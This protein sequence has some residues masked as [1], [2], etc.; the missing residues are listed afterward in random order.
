[1]GSRKRKL[2]WSVAAHLDFGM[3]TWQISFIKFLDGSEIKKQEHASAS[4]SSLWREWAY[5]AYVRA[6]RLSTLPSPQYT[7]LLSRNLLGDHVFLFCSR[8]VLPCAAISNRLTLR[9]QIVFNDS[10]EVGYQLTI[11]RSHQTHNYAV[12]ITLKRVFIPMPFEDH[13]LYTYCTITYSTA[14]VDLPARQ[15]RTER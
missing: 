5:P 15:T 14:F 11:F 4:S 6:K 7:S 2:A 9:S 3:F 13:T 12:I 1:M 10:Q 8:S